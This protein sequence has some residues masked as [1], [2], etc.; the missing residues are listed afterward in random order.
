MKKILIA[1]ILA[2]AVAAGYL[3][4]DEATLALAGYL[5]LD[6]AA[7]E[8]VPTMRMVPKSYAVLV[9]AE[10]ELTGKQLTPVQAPRLRTGSP[11]K[12]GWIAAEGQVVEPGDLVVRFDSTDAEVSL[13]KNQNTVAT[14]DQRIGKSSQDFRS[15]KHILGMDLRQAE[16]EVDF[17]TNQVKSDESIF[18]RWEIRESQVSAELAGFK[19]SAI[20]IK[21]EVKEK[22]TEA[23]LQ[24]LGIERKRA[25]SEVQIAEET[26][27]SL[28][29]RSP[30]Q[31]IVL[32]SRRGFNRIEVGSQVWPGR[33]ILELAALHQYKGKLWIRENEISGIEAGLPV[34][35]KLASFPQRTF[36]ASIQKVD[37]VPQQ[38]S[39]RD[40]RKYFSCEVVLDIPSDIITQL[41][42]GMRIEGR[43]RI[44]SR[45]DA[46]IVP[47]SAIIKKEDEFVAFVKNGEGFEER[48]VK[49]I[50]SD[51]G[52]Y[53]IEGV[54]AGSDL[55]LRDPFEDQ[56]LHLP[57]FN[58]PAA[59]TSARRYVVVM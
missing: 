43:V 58:A 3:Y 14:Y 34:E 17:A 30:S 10:G 15:E 53:V 1:A 23:D 9:P 27:S 2:G 20:E 8:P 4:K 28:E 33:P 47:K 46:F 59:R 12:I 7:K 22:V 32:Y 45:D 25:E 55:A 31:G 41:K 29:V 5:Y 35:L 37:K 40:P 48:T 56:K 24:I 13:E 21:G 19:K 52:F 42:P 36:S 38:P 57:D 39:H 44:S 11:L 6:E 26:L 49:I 51:H 54:E 18:S 50:E 16:M